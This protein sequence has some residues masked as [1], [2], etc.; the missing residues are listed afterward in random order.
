MDNKK[1]IGMDVHRASISV[2]Y[3]ALRDRWC[4]GGAAEEITK[5]TGA[6]CWTTRVQIPRAVS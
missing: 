3:G 5:A 1:Y 2:G 6:K 4:S